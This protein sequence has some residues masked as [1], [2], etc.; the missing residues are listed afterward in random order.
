MPLIVGCIWAAGLR[1]VRKR[2]ATAMQSWN[3]NTFATIIT[4]RYNQRALSC[5]RHLWLFV[6][7]QQFIVFIALFA[8]NSA[9]YMLIQHILQCSLQG[10]GDH[11]HVQSI[12]SVRAKSSHCTCIH[13]S[14]IACTHEHFTASLLFE[15]LLQSRASVGD[16][17][18][19]P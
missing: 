13:R 1:W 17:V 9:M 4:C 18:P 5:M 8:C 14:G 16:R 10:L 6:V 12:Y 7:Y 2:R 19:Y 15:P 3:M 11:A